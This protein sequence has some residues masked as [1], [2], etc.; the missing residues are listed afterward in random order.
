MISTRNSREIAIF[1]GI[2]ACSCLIIAI[3]NLAVLI[4]RPLVSASST[5]AKSSQQMAF[6]DS[7]IDQLNK[8]V[9]VNNLEV[10]VTTAQKGPYTVQISEEITNRGDKPIYVKAY[11]FHLMDDQSGQI[12]NPSQQDSFDKSINPGQTERFESFFNIPTTNKPI[13]LSLLVSNQDAD[14]VNRTTKYIDLGQL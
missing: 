5:V 9:R 1:G 11:D 3:V 13:H 7:D 14:G 4:P 12:Y 10:N 2:I 6:S 8:I